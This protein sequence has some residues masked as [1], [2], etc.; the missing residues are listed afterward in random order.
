MTWRRAANAEKRR[1]FSKES[2]EEGSWERE[3]RME[4][5]ASSVDDG[6]EVISAGE[7]GGSGGL[8]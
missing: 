7:S 4:F 2:E 3:R 1:G 6:G 8:T 5:S